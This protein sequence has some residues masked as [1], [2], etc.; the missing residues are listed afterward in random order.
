[1]FVILHMYHILRISSFIHANRT[2]QEHE[3]NRADEIAHKKLTTYINNTIAVTKDD[4]FETQDDEKH[5]RAH[6]DNV[7]DNDII[8]TRKITSPENK[9]DIMETGLSK[10]IREEKEKSKQLENLLLK[11]LLY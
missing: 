9:N 7:N 6:D 2:R 8:A 5:K 4:N 1:M 3:N 10:Q 11:A